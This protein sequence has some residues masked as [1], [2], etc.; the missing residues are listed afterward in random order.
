M[1]RSAVLLLGCAACTTAGGT[2]RPEAGDAPRLAWGVA[3]PEGAVRY[4]VADTGALTMSIPGMGEAPV[5]IRSEVTADLA[6][7]REREGG[8]R[9]TA[10]V[11]ALSG[12]FASP[13][14]APITAGPQ[15]VPPPAVLRVSP[16]GVVTLADDVRFAGALAQVTSPGALY[17]S[18][19]VR[20]P[21]DVVSRGSTWTDTVR[22]AEEQA[23]MTSRM[24]QVVRSTWARDTVLDG[25]PV[26]VITSDITT[27]I[28]LSGSNQGVEVEQRM[29]G[30]SSA[31]ALWDPAQGVLV[32]RTERGTSSGSADLPG[33]NMNG[34][35][36]NASSRQVVRRI[37]H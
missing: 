6:F 34:I 37:P 14:G 3:R 27:E 8:L 36:V 11:T 23:G 31:V 33:L 20:L 4:I 1:N 15:D 21:A 2:G 26:I 5:D 18:F 29:S 13:A 24:T 19:F 16:Q 9:V 32:E 28:E 22:T 17:R 12:S 25:R 10:T 35:P 7:E 30:S